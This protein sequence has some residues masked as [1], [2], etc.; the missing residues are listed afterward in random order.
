MQDLV[1]RALDSLVESLKNPPQVDRGECESPI[2]EEF[3]LALNKVKNDNVRIWKQRDV[4][5]NIGRFRLDFQIELVG[6]QMA[7]GIECDGRE[8]HS[9]DR[10]AKRDAAIV[11]SGFVD[12]IYRITGHDI[13]FHLADLIQ[14]LAAQEP[15]ILSERGATNVA[16]QAHPEHLREDHFGR[17]GIYFSFAGVRYYTPPDE[18]SCIEVP[19][20]ELGP[21]R[22]TILHWTQKEES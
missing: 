17:S 11:A 18:D 22:P 8:F 5:T 4:D 10:D 14:L 15:W 7:I 3:Y 12:K 20:G 2:E 6:G 1:I 13:C 19:V 16:R 9:P 21:F